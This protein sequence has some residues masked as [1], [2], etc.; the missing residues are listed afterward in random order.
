LCWDGQAASNFRTSN[1]F[2]YNSTDH[3][4]NATASQVPYLSGAILNGDRGALNYASPERGVYG[5]Y[6]TWLSPVQG[7][8]PAE[9][10]EVFPNI[11]IM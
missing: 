10:G 2:Q 4:I 9:W 11:Q 7:T 3:R 6:N 5:F 1:Q 8:L